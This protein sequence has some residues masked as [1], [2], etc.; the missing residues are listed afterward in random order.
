MTDSQESWFDAAVDL[1]FDFI[2][3]DDDLGELLLDGSEQ[4]WSDAFESGLTPQQS[5]SALRALL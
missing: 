3:D 5:L 2:R 4:F 1:V